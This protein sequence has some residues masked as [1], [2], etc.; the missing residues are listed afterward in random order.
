MM[1]NF[2]LETLAKLIY[3]D[4]IAKAQQRRFARSVKVSRRDSGDEYPGF[5]IREG[6]P[7][8]C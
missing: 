7:C 8:Q 5:V 2:E 1:S 3:E 4:T 6:K